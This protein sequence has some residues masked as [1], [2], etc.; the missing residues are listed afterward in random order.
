MKTLVAVVLF[1]ASC[2][3]VPAQQAEVKEKGLG[4][5]K[6]VEG[7]A[8]PNRA[9]RCDYDEDRAILS[10]PPHYDWKAQEQIDKN[11]TLLFDHCEDA[12]PF[13]I[14]GC[15]DSRY[16]MTV[17]EERPDAYSRSVGVIC[18]EV[19]ASYVEVFRKDMRF[20]GPL[21]WHQYDF[22]PRLG[23][24]QYNLVPGIHTATGSRPAYGKK[25]I[26]DF[27]RVH[28]GKSLRG[29]QLEA[30]DCAIEKRKG[31][32]ERLSQGKRDVYALPESWLSRDIESLVAA[33]EKLAKSDK[34]L[35]PRRMS[36][37]VLS[38][39]GYR[40]VPSTEKGQ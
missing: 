21:Q 13:L 8:S 11:R 33:R 5:R 29:L 31:E 19:N 17:T 10:I 12:L 15:T 35:P 6:L 25:E 16:S 1:L 4:Y 14:E 37:S 7:L 24:N 39:K 23:W 26:Q 36:S 38:P 2:H 18:S 20:N 32:K 9:I 40:V 30:F 27:W 34:C 22:I 28:A 3:L